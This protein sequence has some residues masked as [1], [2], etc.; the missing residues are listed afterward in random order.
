MATFT[1][2]LPDVGEGIAEA[3]I[4]AWHVAVGDT[5]EEDQPLVDVMT[6][7]A[8]VEIPSPV[9]GK[10]VAL[11]GAP[12]DRRQ[13]GAELVVLETAAAVAAI[14]NDKPVTAAAP[15]VDPER[16]DRPP[17]A[18]PRAET[19]APPSSP[20]AAPPPS[21]P[22]PAAPPS[23]PGSPDPA[24]RERTPPAAPA[25]R[26][27]ARELGIDLSSVRGADPSG[28]I[29]HQDLDAL[30]VAR[31]ASSPDRTSTA[32]YDEDVE[33]IRIT[34]L[35][36]RIAERMQEAKRRI[37]HFSY[38]EEVD[39]TGVE[40]LRSY[41]NEKNQSAELPRLSLL[42]FLMLAIVKAARDYPQINATFD[43][44]AGVVYRHK[45]VHIGIATQTDA[46]L[47]V[48]VVRNVQTRDLW[49]CASEVARIAAAARRGR[50]TR[51]ELTGSTIT[52]TS[53]GALGGVASTP[54]INRPEVAIVGVNKI[55]ERPVV[56]AGNIVVRRMM[57][58]SSS[59]DHRV[60]DGWHAA[61]FIQ[62]VKA[63]LEQ[64]AALFIE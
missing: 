57:N 55:I 45:P 7:K 13:V 12:G 48:P 14:P 59:F 38:I 58:L 23:A 21:E 16:R 3:E 60:V 1:F 37:P 62:G 8:T 34:G 49:A 40:E 56:R 11:H 20:A 36:R 41:L 44:D 43:D 22:A 32:D 30:L 10:V 54:V 4:T 63:L 29:T 19:P 46:G 27:R 64:P 53:L 6:D 33:E 26:R 25:V 9:A 17:A 47:L 5:I 35:R 2:K 50:S 24:P 42:P 15:P 28:R 61:Q 51:D 39:A 31:Q 18:A 52:I